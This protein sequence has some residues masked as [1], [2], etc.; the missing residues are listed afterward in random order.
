MAISIVS[1]HCAQIESKI[2]SMQSVEIG[3]FK[4][5]MT[6]S[7]VVK[8]FGPGQ[9][10]KRDLLLHRLDGVQTKLKSHKISFSNYQ[11]V[12]KFY[13]G[14]TTEIQCKCYGRTR[15]RGTLVQCETNIVGELIDRANHFFST[16]GISLPA[17][18][19]F[20]LFKIPTFEYFL[21]I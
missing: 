4:N 10:Q 7:T 19:W 11:I 5:Y 16:R 15:F 8:Q 1:G 9:L 12:L 6:D 13:T 20:E 2:Q 21:K 14:F 18:F 17:C 3:L